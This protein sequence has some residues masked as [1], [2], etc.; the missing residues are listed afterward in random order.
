MREFCVVLILI[1]LEY[2]TD[3]DTQR[4]KNDSGRVL[5]LIL[6]EYCTDCPVAAPSRS[7]ALFV[8]ILILLEYCTDQAMPTTTYIV[9]CLN[10]YSSGI[11][12]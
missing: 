2:C 4:G 5:I 9:S 3:Y 12:H 8:L 1:L 10:P 6:L 7:R 11:L